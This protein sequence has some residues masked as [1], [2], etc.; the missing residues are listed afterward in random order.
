[1]LTVRRA[2]ALRR[3]PASRHGLWQRLAEKKNDAALPSQAA[4]LTWMQALQDAADANLFEDDY[5]IDLAE[6]L[7]TGRYADVYV[8]YPRRHTYAGVI[9]AGAIRQRRR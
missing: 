9:R 3:A 1:M 5:A 7:G 6:Q 4:Y 2:P 8:C